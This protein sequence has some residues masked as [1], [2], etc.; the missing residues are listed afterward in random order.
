MRDD[1]TRQDIYDV[2][3]IGFG[4][5]NLALGVALEEMGVDGAEGPPLRRLFLESK[6][7][8]I[9]HPGMLIEDSQ[10]QISVLKDLATIRNPQS[11]F[12]FLN[13]LKIRGRLFEFLNLR[14]LFPSRIEFND[15]LSWVAGELKDSVRYGKE[16]LSVLPVEDAGEVQLLRVRARDVATGD[17]DELLTRNIVLATGGI[18]KAPDGIQLQPG[19]RA[20]HSHES[21][22]R[23]KRDF[24][25]REA[26]YRFVVVGSG[27]SAAELFYYLMCN[28]PN[29]DVTGSIRRFAYKPVD[30]SDFTNEIFFPEMV[31]FLYGLPEEKRRMVLDDCRD[32]NYAVVD[33]ALIRRIYKALYQEKVL[34][35]NRARVR[36]FLQLQG[37]LETGGAVIAQFRDL[38]RD[39]DVTLEA[40]GMIICTGYTWRKQHPL[41]AD[42]GPFLHKNA[43]DAYH[44]ERDYRL[45][46]G[47]ALTAGV[48][49]QGFAEE[50]HG[51]SETVLSLLAIRAE[52]IVNNLLATRAARQAVENYAL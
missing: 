49:L 47:P 6:A 35:R 38:L 29:A 8:A 7:K 41:L 44:I 16:V 37:L 15:Y 50:T 2:I 14:D 39:E 31:D 33:L 43:S 36:S 9:W 52:H 1:N 27:Q 30:D 20:F 18:P 10:I 46:A 51:A 28:Y 42:V 32:V 17:V 3:G 13:Y 5:A 11:R 4:P 22:L 34:G 12:T 26:P 45:A 48:F 25:D 19:G 40:D 24:P 21:M 23:M